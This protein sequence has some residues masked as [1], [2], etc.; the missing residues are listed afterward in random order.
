MTRQ[1]KIQLIKA[2]QAGEE[3]E[4]P[5]RKFTEE[6]VDIIIRYLRFSD[7][8]EGH[9]KKVTSEDLRIMEAAFKRLNI[10]QKFPK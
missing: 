8:P 7:S 3:I 5:N 6:E 4:L 1:E 2:Y 10:Q 9:P